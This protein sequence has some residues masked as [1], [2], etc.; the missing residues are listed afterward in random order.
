MLLL[1]ID[2]ETTYSTPVNPMLARPIEVGA[3]LWDVKRKKPLKMYSEL[4]YHP[5]HPESPK[6]LVSLTGIDDEM[7]QLYGDIP[8]VVMTELNKLV[9]MAD[10][11]VAHNGNEFDK[12]V[13]QEECERLSLQPVDRPWIDTKTDIP[14]RDGVRTTK[15]TYL[16]AEH[17]FANPF[18]HRALFDV[19]S[20]LH[21]LNMYNIK[22]VVELSKQPNVRVIASVSYQD[23]DLAKERGYHWDG[24]NKRW[25]KILKEQKAQEEKSQ[26]PFP[27]QV[28]MSY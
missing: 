23:K 24:E 9:K 2:F 11:V 1:G 10:Y 5:D 14:F 22:E 4:I 28:L 8:A 3:V 26:A 19:L 25:T 27:V 21:L 13:Y 16:C 6:E 17:G 12:V 7:R 18:Q 15:L 20:M